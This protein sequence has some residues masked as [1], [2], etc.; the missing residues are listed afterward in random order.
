MKWE[1]ENDHIL[2]SDWDP[3]RMGRRWHRR[4]VLFCGYTAWSKAT[5]GRPRAFDNLWHHLDAPEV[6][7]LL[8]LATQN[9]L[10]V[11]M[12]IKS[13]GQSR[14]RAAVACG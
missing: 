11:W 1:R 9:R 8:S 4:R 12:Y 6:D 5:E 3:M 10:V 13:F 2:R 7:D 14:L